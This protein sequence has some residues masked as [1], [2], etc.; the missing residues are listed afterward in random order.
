METR[1]PL[2]PTPTTEN[3]V[4]LLQKFIHLRPKL[5]LP[6][7]VVRFKQQISESFKNSKTGGP[8]DFHF[9][10]HIFIILAQRDSPPTMGELSADLN[11]PFS[12]A[13]R[14]VDGL[15]Q[16]HFVERFSDPDDRRIVRVQMT[17]NGREFYQ[18]FLDYNQDRIEHLL[19][20]FSTEEKCQLYHLM[21]KLLDSLES[22]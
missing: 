1:N 20:N 4:E 8:D 3:F 18:T 11:T 19:N 12:T 2:T 14:I 10:F 6:D 7:R 17:S 16:S 13:T 9:I 22:G 21:S 15:V 5:I